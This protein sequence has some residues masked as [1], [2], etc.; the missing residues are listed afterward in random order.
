MF[1]VNLVVDIDLK[2]KPNDLNKQTML[3]TSN[4]PNYGFL[5]A[6]ALKESTIC[7]LLIYISNTTSIMWLQLLM[8]L[9]I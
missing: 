7:M 9:S 6:K 1:K 2:I 8:D 3:L 5:L 4:E